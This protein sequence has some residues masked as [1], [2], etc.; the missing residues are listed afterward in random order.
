MRKILAILLACSLCGCSGI[1]VNTYHVK[2]YKPEIP[3]DPKPEL[4]KLEG[5]DLNAF[6][7]LPAGTQKILIEN[8][9]ALMLDN[10]KMRGNISK[11]NDWAETDN[12]ASRDA[13]EGKAPKKKE[14]TDAKPD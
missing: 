1:S 2:D 10:Q 11:Y 13:L 14:S 8:S 5:E 7:A 3:L 9:D 6:K 12:K 4:K